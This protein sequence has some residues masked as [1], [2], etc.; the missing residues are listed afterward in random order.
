MKSCENQNSQ[1]VVLQDKKEKVNREKKTLKG[2][3]SPDFK[4]A[5]KKKLPS[6]SRILGKHSKYGT[7]SMGHLI[8][9]K[10]STDRFWDQFYFPGAH[11]D[12]YRQKPTTSMDWIKVLSEGVEM[13]GQHTF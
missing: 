9:M 10:P 6:N 1:L 13:G 11:Q 7:Q 5:E 4:W 3:K 12:C 8:A 2:H